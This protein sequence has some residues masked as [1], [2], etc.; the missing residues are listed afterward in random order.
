MKKNDLHFLLLKK[1]LM[2]SGYG[3]ND[4]IDYDNIELDSEYIYIK[5]NDDEY[6]L[7]IENYMKYHNWWTCIER[8]RKINEIFS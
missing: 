5:I 1:I 8:N 3:E 6:Q 4:Y 7:R 2:E